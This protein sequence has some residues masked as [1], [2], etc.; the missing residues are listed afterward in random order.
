MEGFSAETLISKLY[1]CFFLTYTPNTINTLGFKGMVELLDRAP[2]DS[3]I[4]QVLGVY[5]VR[6]ET[7]LVAHYKTARRWC[8][9][10]PG[11]IFEFLN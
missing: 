6:N 11:N 4:S 1:I 5:L 8:L 10:R 7:K 9:A 2:T 3:Q